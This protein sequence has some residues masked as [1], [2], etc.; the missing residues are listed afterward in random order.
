MWTRVAA[1]HNRFNGLATLRWRDH[2]RTM[3]GSSSRRFAAASGLVLILAG[4]A[5]ALAASGSAQSPRLTVERTGHAG[6][7]GY[8]GQMTAAAV[9]YSAPV[10]APL[11]V[12]N[13][14]RAPPTPYSAGHR[15]VDFAVDPGTVVWAA[16]SGRVTFAGAVAGRGIVVLLHPD[17]VSTEYEPIVASVRVGQLVARGAPVGRVSGSHDGCPPDRCLHWGARR[18]GQY[19]DPMS[20]LEPLGPVR[21]LPWS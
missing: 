12:L 13:P 15:G 14:F 17:G 5:A 18:A 16:G 6:H 19:F 8:A 10:A 7:A 4:A 2:G 1:V 20:L 3:L 21:L 9:T 11:H